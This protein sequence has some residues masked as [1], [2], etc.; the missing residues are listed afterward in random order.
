MCAFNNK[1]TANNV[2]KCSAPG[3]LQR[4]GGN[5][6]SKMTTKNIVEDFDCDLEGENGTDGKP[7][8]KEEVKIPPD[9]SL[10]DLNDH[11]D[12]VLF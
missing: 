6:E 10:I 4:V 1:T 2:K 7:R 12:E 8:F 5:K 9:Y 11:D 3:E